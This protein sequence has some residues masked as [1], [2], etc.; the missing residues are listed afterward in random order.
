MIP[1]EPV[2]R[3]ALAGVLIGPALVSAV[4]YCLLTPGPDGG[5]MPHSRLVG[6]AMY[7]LAY[8]LSLLRVPFGVIPYLCK[9]VVFLLFPS[10]YNRTWRN[11]NAWVLVRLIG[12]FASFAVTALLLRR[13]GGWLVELSIVAEVLRLVLEKGQSLISAGWQRLPH[14]AIAARLKVS[15]GPLG[16]YRA[17]YS[18]DDQQRIA[19][20][21]SALRRFSRA[22][23]EAAR[24]V[25]SVRGL[26]VVPDEVGLG[27]GL[28]RDVAAGEVFIHRR[29]TADPFLLIGVA[30]RRGPWLFDPRWLSRPFYYRTEANR[31]MTLFV[32]E[33]L[34]YCPTFALYQ[35]GNEIKSAR[36]DFVQRMLGLIGIQYDWPVQQDGN[37]LFDPLLVRLTGRREKGARPVWSDPEVFADL[38]GQKLTSQEIAIRYCYPL[39]YVEEVLLPAIEGAQKAGEL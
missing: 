31:L 32:L 21:L 24:K 34:A 27:S 14:R 5:P 12:D 23:H 11:H 3:L 7:V 22:D 13:F 25:R 30:M 9:A 19:Y 10:F 29:W 28:V 39:E 17:Y 4:C 8:G 37:Y 18:L 15:K 26:R 35:L 36:Y 2:A 38:E 1:V 6:R 20:A 16:R 33:H